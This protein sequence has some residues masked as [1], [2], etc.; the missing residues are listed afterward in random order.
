[1]RQKKVKFMIV[2]L[3]I[4]EKTLA[5]ERADVKQPPGDTAFARSSASPSWLSKQEQSGQQTIRRT[6]W[7]ETAGRPKQ[8]YQTSST[9]HQV[10]SRQAPASETGKPAAQNTLNYKLKPGIQ[11]A[12]WR[13]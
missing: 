6:F 5:G 9:K 11:I 13:Q 10:N 2:N 1:M 3:I 8:W 4:N 12:V 7:R